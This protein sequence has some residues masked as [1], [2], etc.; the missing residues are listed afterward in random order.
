MKFLLLCF[1]A[2][3]MSFGSTLTDQRGGTAHYP[4]TSLISGLLGN[5]LG[6]DHRDV[7]SLQS[8]QDRLVI[9]VREDLRGEILQDYQTVDLGQEFMQ[10]AWTT[11]GDVATR[12]GGPAS[13]GT[14]I[15][16][17]DFLAEAEY[18]VALTLNP[19]HEPPILD[20]LEAALRSPARPLFLGRKCCLPTARI[21]RGQVEAEGLKDALA[22]APLSRRANE[23][24]TSDQTADRLRLWL[25]ECE[26]GS[27]SSPQ[28]TYDLRDWANQVHTGRRL[29][30]E[31]YVA[32]PR[33]EGA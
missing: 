19:S 10:K 30:R 6:Y 2:P 3:L 14:H 29:I 26:E 9:G 5:A 13:R 8:L 27:G 32:P 11:R 22:S 25:P 21:A 4:G 16:Y 15:R 12:A 24:S 17:R 31:H 7:V 20:D 1:Q 33:P 28:P 23:R 18:T